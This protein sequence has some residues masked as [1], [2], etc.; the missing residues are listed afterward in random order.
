MR[1]LERRAL[2]SDAGRAVADPKFS[3]KVSKRRQRG[4]R[5]ARENV[6]ALVDQ[7]SFFE[8]GRFAVAAQ[9]GR[10]SSTTSSRRPLRTVWCAA[11]GA[12]TRPPSGRRAVAQL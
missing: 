12:S 3:D 5:T 9:R 2:I 4:Q 11:L 7:G 10:R 1:V 6:D 8:Y